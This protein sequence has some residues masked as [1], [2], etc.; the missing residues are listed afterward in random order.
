MVQPFYKPMDRPCVYAGGY[1]TEYL[2]QNFMRSRLMNSTLVIA[3]EEL[4]SNP[5]MVAKR[6][7][8][9]M[10]HDLNDLNLLNFTKIRVN[11]QENKGLLCYSGRS[12]GSRCS[13]SISS[14]DIFGDRRGDGCCYSGSSSCDSSSCGSS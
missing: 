12:D 1:Y 10:N 13:G 5:Y 8:S 4:D 3:S 7:A 11:S 9:V 6:V 2:E 14:R